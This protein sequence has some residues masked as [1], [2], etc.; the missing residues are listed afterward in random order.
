M[1]QLSDC[2]RLLR[3]HDYDRFLTGLFAP[4]PRREALFA[5]YAFNLEIARTREAVSEPM[6]GQ[7]RLQWWRETI[8]EIYQGRVRR[9]EVVQPLAATIADLSLPRDPFDRLI[10]AREND[11]IDETPADLSALADY[12]RRTGGAIVRLAGLTLGTVDEATRAA[13]DAAGTAYALAGI[14]RAVP[15]HARA[16]RQFLPADLVRDAGLK[17]SDYFELRVV[18]ALVPVVEA[19]AGQA[20]AEIAAARALRGRVDRAALPALAHARLAEL[21]LAHLA[22]GGYQP[23]RPRRELSTLRKQLALYWA[24]R[25]GR[26]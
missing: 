4:A 24:M 22:R 25:R 1:S 26:F 3:R 17:P 14:L 12:A 2:A 18:D 19:I 8:E 13:L 16:K 15:F 6:L 21:Y 5:V 11:L 10:D 7:I 20:R 9:H 23:M